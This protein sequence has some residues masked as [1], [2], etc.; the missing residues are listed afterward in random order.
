[1]KNTKGYSIEYK[2]LTLYHYKE[3]KLETDGRV[4]TLTGIIKRELFLTKS[5]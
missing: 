5:V 1:M 3:L 2:R 4:R